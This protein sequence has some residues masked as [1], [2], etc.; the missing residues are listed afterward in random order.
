MTNLLF[1]KISD[2]DLNRD[3]ILATLEEILESDHFANAKRLEDFLRFIVMEIVEGRSSHLKSYTIGLEVF[4]RRIDYDAFNDSIVRTTANRLRKAL[5][6]Y[7]YSSA[8]KDGV[9]ISLQKGS[10]VPVFHLYNANS[11]SAALLAP[12]SIPE[13]APKP[14]RW[15]REIRSNGAYALLGLFLLPIALY[16]GYAA[17][18]A[19]APA[20]AQRPILLL[21]K[22]VAIGSSRNADELVG[23]ISERLSPALSG[24]GNVTVMES[25]DLSRADTLSDTERNDT[26][27]LQVTVDGSSSDNTVNWRLT[28]IGKQ[29]VV[30]AGRTIGNGADAK[31]IVAAIAS[32]ILG[33]E[34]ALSV[35]LSENDNAASTNLKCLA[36]S[37]RRALFYDDKL[38]SDSVDCLSQIVANE[39]DNGLAWA[40]LSLSY[41]W[42]SQAASS[43]GQDPQPFVEL[44]REAA[45][46]ADY[47][48][49]GTYLTLQ[50]RMFTAF[51]VGRLATFDQV[52]AKL[53][54]LFTLD[55]FLKG[56]IGLTVSRLGRFDEALE[57]A[58]EA[59]AEADQTGDIFYLPNA[60]WE[61]FNAD[62]KQSIEHLYMANAE[63]Y[64]MV[65]LFRAAAFGSLGDRKQAMAAWQELQALR[66][67][68]ERHLDSD[69]AFKRVRQ[70]YT[71]KVVNGLRKAGLM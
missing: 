48:A 34:G 9:R 55:P 57:L 20:G 12:A 47:L 22:V 67:G 63:K 4:K 37:Q 70:D 44:Q 40:L 32:D 66:P 33:T 26:F 14:P 30:G 62:Y 61:F 25:N 38:Q 45:E 65:P 64:Y 59:Q 23:F 56:R 10:Y 51:N 71:D 42:S 5:D 21:D 16:G 35:V 19:N 46:K 2:Y 7:N 24:Y 17:F 60:Y 13:T 52:A 6:A 11:D 69:F 31:T 50:A 28:Y 41:N 27:A 29:R 58:R 36:R 3:S 43:Y 8:A 68:Y 54:Q 39:P 49:P 1:E 15:I 53:R 18:V